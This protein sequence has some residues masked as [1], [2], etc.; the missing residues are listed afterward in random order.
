MI[1][2]IKQHRKTTPDYKYLNN[3]IAKAIK[4]VRVLSRLALWLYSYSS[5][6]WVDG[7]LAK[8]QMQ[9]LVKRVDQ[10]SER[11]LEL[12]INHSQVFISKQKR[13]CQNLVDN[14]YEFSLMFKHTTP[15]ND[16]FIVKYS[17]DNFRE[18]ELFRH[19]KIEP[20]LNYFVV[21]NGNDNLFYVALNKC[22]NDISAKQRPNGLEFMECESAIINLFEDDINEARNIMLAIKQVR[23]KILG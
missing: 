3:E 12:L 8:Q 13:I 18:I 10:T 23:D 19:D 22:L 11:L 2:T 20:L 14:L 17:F 7:G 16:R 15:V 9:E 4:H 21:A 5:D 6:D 1:A